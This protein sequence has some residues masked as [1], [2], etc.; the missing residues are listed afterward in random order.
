MEPS[1]VRKSGSCLYMKRNED[2]GYGEDYAPTLYCKVPINVNCFKMIDVE[3][4]EEPGFVYDIT[5]QK[6]KCFVKAVLHFE[7]IFVSSAY[8]RIQ[9]KLREFNIEVERIK[10]RL[11]SKVV[12]K[13]KEEEES[14]DDKKEWE[15]EE[16]KE[17]EAS[18]LI[19]L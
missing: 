3:D 13:T 5:K 8:V 19:N 17:K 9:V 4:K 10:Q 1:Y 11:L 15:L 2:G 12:A 7:S 16:E 6:K 18:P 14:K